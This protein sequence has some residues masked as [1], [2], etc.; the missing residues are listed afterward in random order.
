MKK[1]QRLQELMDIE[2]KYLLLK[3]K[4]T[5][6]LRRRQSLNEFVETSGNRAG[7]Q[8]NCPHSSSLVELASAD[9]NKPQFAATEQVAVS[10]NSGMVKVSV[11]GT[12]LESGAPK[13]LLGVVCVDFTPG[14][15]TISTASLYW[16]SPKSTPAPGSMFPSVSVLSFES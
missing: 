15:A 6:D 13:T 1:K 14:T 10:G 3:E 16:S 11:H 4:E 8:S 2:K 9:M 12:D 7:Q 5:L